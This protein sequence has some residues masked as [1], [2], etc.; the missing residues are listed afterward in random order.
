MVEVSKLGISDK[1]KDK[2]ATGHFLLT[3]EGKERSNYSRCTFW[4]CGKSRFDY[5]RYGIRGPQCRGLAKVGPIVIS[6]WSV[7]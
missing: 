5:K 2:V 3:M 4:Y 6:L 1:Q 7:R